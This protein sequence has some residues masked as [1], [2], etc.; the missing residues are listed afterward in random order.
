MLVVGKY[1]ND[2]TEGRRRKNNPK[3]C[4]IM[5]HKW[6]N[7][8]TSKYVKNSYNICNNSFNL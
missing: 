5:Q 2:S 3:N 1:Q 6:R 8:S 7:A 4:K